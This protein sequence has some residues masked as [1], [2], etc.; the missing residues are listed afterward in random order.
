M[1]LNNNEIRTLREIMRRF[2]VTNG[3]NKLISSDN[4]I[5]ITSTG[6]HVTDLKAIGGG[7]GDFDWI[8]KP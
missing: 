4:S 7:S 6:C 5:S 2:R 1:N 8:L 3:L